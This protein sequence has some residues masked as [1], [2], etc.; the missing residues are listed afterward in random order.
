MIELKQIFYSCGHTSIEGSTFGNS[1]QVAI[2]NAREAGYL[3]EENST[4]P[5]R[6]CTVKFQSLI[7]KN[8]NTINISLPII[9]ATGNKYIS[10]LIKSGIPI[11]NIQNAYDWGDGITAIV[12]EEN[13]KP[14]P[15][16]IICYKNK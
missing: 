6:I 8:N 16:G 3:T 1:P 5:C 13:G 7:T 4:S 14:G 11:V 12:F 10:K 2:E 9:P 15:A